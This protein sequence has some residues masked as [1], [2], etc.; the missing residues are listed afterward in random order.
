MVRAASDS[1]LTSSHY[2]QTLLEQCERLGLAPPRIDD[3]RE[4]TGPD[5]AQRD[6][7]G[8]TARL[9]R[10]LWRATGDEL[11][12]FSPLPLRPGSFAVMCD[13]MISA[14]TLGEFLR[15]AERIAGFLLP[16][17]IG[18]ALEERAQEAVVRLSSPASDY[19]SK[20]FF[21]EF[22]AVIWHRIPCWSIDERIELQRVSFSYPKP[23]HAEL[24]DELFGCEIRFDEPATALQ[25][26]RR[27][28]S[29]PIVRSAADMEAFL[30]HSP[31]DLLYLPGKRTSMRSRIVTMLMVSV[32][33]STGFPTF[34][35]I[36]GQL[37][38]S[39]PSVRRRLRK[40]GTCYRR[41]KNAVRRD[42]AM[43]LLASSDMTI[44]DIA[45]SLGFAEP[46]ALTRAF[47]GWTNET[48]QA[49]R[50][51]HAHA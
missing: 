47:K 24:Y 49:Y 29:R 19:D 7:S 32:R 12:G 9:I 44:A 41:L 22:W 13:Y 20:R 31:Q 3:Q 37:H 5:G 34:D 45:M 46:A 10:Y 23:A 38:M 18:L 35:T 43:E 14:V 11:M 17:S 40:E 51:R 30:R 15:R 28:L 26:D 36:C 33:E 8:L 39:P 4:V 2:L 6:A 16:A 21:A 1:R 25:F 48:P 27:Y 42:R 50:Q